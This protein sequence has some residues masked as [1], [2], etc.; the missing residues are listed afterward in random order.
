VGV[1]GGEGKREGNE[2]K[3]QCFVV[4]RVQRYLTEMKNM[5]RSE[6]GSLLSALSSFTVSLLFVSRLFRFPR[7][8]PHGPF[9]NNNNK[10]GQYIKNFRCPSRNAISQLGGFPLG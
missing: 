8:L 7:H 3:P 1:D 2:G 6:M 5:L 4:C 9:N 10:N